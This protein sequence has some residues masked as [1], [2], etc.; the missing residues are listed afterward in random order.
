MACWQGTYTDSTTISTL[1]AGRVRIIGESVDAAG[2]ASSPLKVSCE[3]LEQIGVGVEASI[4]ACLCEAG[5]C[6]PLEMTEPWVKPY[7]ANVANQAI[8]CQISCL[9]PTDCCADD[10]ELAIFFGDLSEKYCK[11][12]GVFCKYIKQKVLPG[13]VIK[14]GAQAPAICVGSFE[15]ECCPPICVPDAMCIQW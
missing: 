4:N 7:I 15:P 1:L 13:E 11:A 5:Y 14:E 12:L 6:L 10:D 3:Q 9:R 2:C 8:I